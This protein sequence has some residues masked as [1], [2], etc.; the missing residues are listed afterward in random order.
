MHMQAW[1]FV[2][3][4]VREQGPFASV[5]EL[6]GRDVNGS[7]RDLF[8]GASYLTVDIVDGPGVDVVADCC[9]WRADSTFAAVVCC[10]VFEHESRWCELCATAYSVLEDGGVAILTMAG[11]GREPHSAV[12]GGPLRAGEFYGNVSADELAVALTAA[13]F[14]KVAVDGESQ[15]GD[16]YALAWKT[17]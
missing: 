8:A 5:V 15:Y 7:V 3:Q 6:G 9:T 11:P 10:E 17:L 4:A 2:A 16:T 12:D 1:A 14:A 13:G